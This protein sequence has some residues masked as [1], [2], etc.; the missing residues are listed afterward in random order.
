[1]FRF[2]RFKVKIF[3]F[4]GLLFTFNQSFASYSAELYEVEILVINEAGDT[5]WR[6]FTEGLNEVFIRISGDSFVMDKLKRPPASQYVK[7]FSYDPVDEPA[8][9]E[10]GEPLNY[11]MKIQYNGH[12]M[13]KYLRDNG[14]AVWGEHRPDVVVWLAVRDGRNEYVLKRNDE[15]LIKAAAEQALKRRGIP[16]S[17]PLYDASDKK[18][19]TVADIRGGFSDP[20]GKASKRYS[21]G[22]ALTGSLIWNGAKWQSSWSLLM[23]SGNHHWSIEETDYKL[24]IDKSINQAGDAMGAVFA[25]HGADK[26][27]KIVSVQ[28]DID[29][30][31]SIKKYRK[32]EDYLS[33]LTAVK[34]VRLLQVDGHRVLFEV[35]LRSTEEDFLNLI[36]NDAQLIKVDFVEPVKERAT[37]E[38][39]VIEP[40]ASELSASEQQDSETLALSP[41][42]N[43]TPQGGVADTQK[44]PVDVVLSEPVIPLYHFKLLN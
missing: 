7:R 44:A 27:Q 22:P 23:D 9:N 30:I 25:I 21:R 37:N 19:L 17:W 26:N 20:V 42:T 16:E 29:A 12:A 2:L 14:F 31:N 33:N 8:A 36:K 32:A 5:R 40:L 39:L 10:K 11:R 35:S 28:L 18:I 4:I 6:A 43:S 1:M 24:L 3:V 13:E 41:A 38:P 15:S 34:A